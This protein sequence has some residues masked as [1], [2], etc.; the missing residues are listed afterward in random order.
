MCTPVIFD[1]LCEHSA[2]GFVSRIAF[3]RATNGRGFHIRTL[4]SITATGGLALA[5]L[6]LDTGFGHSVVIGS[7]IPGHAGAVVV[8]RTSRVM[9]EVRACVALGRVAGIAEA[10][11]DVFASCSVEHISRIARACVKTN[12]IRTRSRK[13]ASTRMTENALIDVFACVCVSCPGERIS[14]IACACVCTIRIGTRSGECGST[15]SAR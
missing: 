5:P 3:A 4:C 9:S 1:T 6:V 11:I 15:G 8:R 2:I 10:L 7:I 13:S 14:R 12:G